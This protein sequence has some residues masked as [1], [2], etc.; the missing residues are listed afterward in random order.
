MHIERGSGSFTFYTESD[1]LPELNGQP[2][3]LRPDYAFES[4]FLNEDW[5]SGVVQIAKDDRELV[6][7]VRENGKD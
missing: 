2:I 4:P 3:D 5:A 6:I 1:Q 7:D